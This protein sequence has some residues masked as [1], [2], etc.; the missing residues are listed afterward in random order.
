MIWWAVVAW[1]VGVGVV[2]W[3]VNKLWADGGESLDSGPWQ[4][5]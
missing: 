4:K 3:V 1:L 2:L 5:R